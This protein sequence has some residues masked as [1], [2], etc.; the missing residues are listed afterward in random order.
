MSITSCVPKEGKYTS[1][2]LCQR[3]NGTCSGSL[4]CEVGEYQP[5]NCRADA[6]CC[7]NYGTQQGTH[8]TICTSSAVCAALKGSCAKSK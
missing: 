7:C 3:M 4:K 5:Q 8:A 6:S 2:Q 1:A